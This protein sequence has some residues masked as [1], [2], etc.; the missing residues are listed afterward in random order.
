MTKIFTWDVLSRGR[1]STTDQ[2]DTLGHKVYRVKPETTS[3][4]LD[5]MVKDWFVVN[6]DRPLSLYKFRKILGL[7]KD[8]NI[9]YV[10]KWR[11]EVVSPSAY[12]LAQCLV[13]STLVH[14]YGVDLVKVD[15]IN[16]ELNKIYLHDTHPDINETGFSKIG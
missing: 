2:G 13:L 10:Y 6:S 15:S 5:K 12:R 14:V 9:N 8:T 1:W 4:L 7:I 3:Y 11:G 16:W